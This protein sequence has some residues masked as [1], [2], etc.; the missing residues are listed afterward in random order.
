M[1][2]APALL[3]AAPLRARPAPPDSP[4]PPDVRT[5]AVRRVRHMADG[6]PG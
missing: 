5:P 2:L 1:P 6:G 4:R 3:D